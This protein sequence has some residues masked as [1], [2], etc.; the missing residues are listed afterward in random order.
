MKI[1]V[2]GDVHGCYHTL[3]S[4]VEKY[5]KPEEQTLIQLGDLINKGPHSG[6]CI[7]YWQKLENDFPGKTVL[8][9]G[10]H[11]QMLLDYFYKKKPEDSVKGLIHNIQTEGL[12][13]EGVCEWLSQK[14][15]KW[16][17]EGILVTHA[18][19][20]KSIKNPFDV[21][22]SKGVL[23]NRSPLKRLDKI[24]VVGHTMIRGGKPVFNP[25]ENAWFMDTGA[26]TKKYL[27]ALSISVNG[28][29]PKVVREQR[30]ELD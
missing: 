25:K 20:S 27:S 5:W 8:L 15:L 11:E 3:S 17:T 21:T 22:N 29:N 6:K 26:W 24:Q 16:E 23:L 10:N 7:R 28:E 1:L 2:I 9:R 18:G 30:S 12:R 4:L 14:A 19:I 13:I